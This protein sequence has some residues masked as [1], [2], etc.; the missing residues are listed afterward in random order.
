MSATPAAPAAGNAWSTLRAWSPVVTVVV[1]LLA[2][3]ASLAIL[4]G[5]AL[6]R[7]E[8]RLRADIATV[9]VDLRADMAA[10]AVDLR[11][12]MADVRADVAELAAE[13]RELRTDVH[14]LSDR[15]ARIEGVL[16]APH[17]VGVGED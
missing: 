8:G 12:D 7:M 11:A 17:A 2:L 3:F 13:V 10:L 5:A 16:T 14:A 9:A 15:V 4:I 1:A 6:G